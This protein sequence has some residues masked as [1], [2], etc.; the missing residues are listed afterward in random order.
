M[1]MPIHHRNHLAN[2]L[3]SLGTTRTKAT[4]ATAKNDP[5]NVAKTSKSRAANGARM[6]SAASKNPA[7]NN[8]SAS[9]RMSGV[10]RPSAGAW[11]KPE[12]KSTTRNDSASP[13][14]SG[15]IPS[16]ASSKSRGGS[17]LERPGWSGG[18]ESG[19]SR[20]KGGNMA[21]ASSGSGGKT[22]SSVGR[23][24]RKGSGRGRGGR[25]EGGKGSGRRVGKGADERKGVS[26]MMAVNGES[27]KRRPNCH[28]ENDVD[29]KYIGVLDSNYIYFQA[30]S[31]GL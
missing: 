31:L 13:R 26:N 24:G 16:A 21:K 29:M 8:G 23:E 2:P 27:N 7:R 15:A 19:G 1:K 9:P 20:T 12:G 11:R 28:V 5:M 18:R 6:S 3:D 4:G 30:L 10:S 22:V 25:R 17:G 14:G